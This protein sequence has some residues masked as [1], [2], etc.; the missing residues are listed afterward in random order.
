MD[1]RAY[2]AAPGISVIVLPDAPVYTHVSVS[3]DFL[4]I[5]RLKKEDVLGKGYSEVFLKSPGDPNTQWQQTVA[6]SFKY[7]LEHGKPHEIQKQRYDLPNPDGSFSER[8]WKINNAP[9]LNETG[10]VLYIIHSSTDITRQVAAEQ[11]IESSQGI[12]E[13]YNIFMNT[14][15]IIGILKGDDYLIELANEG[16]LEVWGRT[17]EVIGKPLLEAIPELEAQGFIALLDNVRTTGEPFYAYEFPI[18]LNRHGTNEVI[19][20]DFVYKAIYDNGNHQKATGI[21]S[22]G[23]DVTA[24]VLARK[25]VE[26]SEQ[27][28]RSLVDSAPFPIGVY[29]GRELRIVLANKS[30]MDVWGKGVDVIGKLYRDI[31]PELENQPIFSQLDTVFATGISFHARNQRVDLLVEGRMQPFYFNYSFTPL[32]DADGNVY[33]IMNTAAEVTDIAIAKQMVEQSEEN[34]RTMVLQAPVA[35]CILLGPTHIVEV[36]N[37]R[38]I[39]LWGK[40]AEVVMG[41]PIFEG[42]PDARD[43]GLEQVLA[44]VYQNGETFTAN[45]RPVELLRNGKWDTVY[46]NFVYEPYKDSSGNILGLFAIAI[47]VTEQVLARQKIEDIVTQRTNEL[48]HANEALVVANQELTHSNENL[49]QFAYAASHDLKEPLR[50]MQVFGDRLRTTIREKLTEEEK[51]AFERMD[52]ASKRMTSLIDDLLT[53]SLVSLKTETFEE[54]NLNEVL[55]TVLSDLDL[56][57]EEKAATINVGKL[58]TIKG[59]RRQ[60]Q[61][62]FQNLIANS[63]KYSKKDARP[64]ITITCQKIGVQDSPSFKPDKKINGNYVA[65]VIKDNGIGF[66]QQDAERIFTVFTRLNDSTH[67]KGTGVGLSIVRKVIENHKGYITAESVVGEGSTFRIILPEIH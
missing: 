11:K 53:Y 32:F 26:E 34:F 23:H 55:D 10:E 58:F 56:E 2:E 39:E 48:A 43:Q 12:R 64:E 5:F 3:N 44:D 54:V 66:D 14:P 19:Y 37:D 29:I 57:I 46:M 21:I 13:A 38:I 60:L 4:Q 17:G 51:H 15:V 41:K 20:F 16:L 52:S 62:A 25:K 7:V 27:R 50:K 63:L 33:G 49:Q 18:T 22:V 45:E 42:L 36:A 40:P 8:Y 28:F 1:F 67:I 6:G 65:C 35:M 47:D 59:E 9:I 61:Q 24:K 31:L 30:M